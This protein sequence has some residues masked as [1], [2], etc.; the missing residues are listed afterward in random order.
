MKI[1]TNKAIKH[2]KENVNGISGRDIVL[3][4]ALLNAITDQLEGH[5]TNQKD[6]L[7]CIYNK[8][9]ERMYQYGTG[10]WTTMNRIMGNAKK[11]HPNA[12]FYVG[13]TEG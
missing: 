8:H 2:I 12:G 3:A 13:E 7:F 9:D 1:D 5:D 6:L 4:Y 11:D 10:D